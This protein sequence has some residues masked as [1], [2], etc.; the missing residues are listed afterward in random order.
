VRAAVTRAFV[1]AM[2]TTYFALAAC[3]TTE[4]L[5]CDTTDWYE[6]GR[7]HGSRGAPDDESKKLNPSCKNEDEKA[8]A[9]ALY[10]NGR[11]LGLA[12][13][14]T[15]SNGFEMGRTGQTYSKV[16]PAVL[17]EAFL[18]GYNRGSRAASLQSI[19]ERL[20]KPGLPF[21]RKGLLEAKKIQLTQ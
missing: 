5:P 3:S 12:E 16:C 14:C 19:N 11:S 20:K 9:L 17:E 15:E 7:R 18:V 21:A 4:K 13:Y 8:D 2:T 1:L 6:L 10:E